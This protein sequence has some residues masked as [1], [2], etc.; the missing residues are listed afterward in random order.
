MKKEYIVLAVVSVLMLQIIVTFEKGE[1]RDHGF[2][3]VYSMTAPFGFFSI[4]GE[5]HGSFLFIDGYI[6]SSENYDV[7]YFDG[8]ILRTIILNAEET[9]VIVD[10]KLLLEREK[11]VDSFDFLHLHLGLTPS[12][13][14]KYTIHIPFLPDVA[15]ITEEWDDS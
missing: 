13:R 4:Q 5:I 11:T 8:N 14:I 9:G 12:L 7:K 10:G 3:D 1:V 2:Y 15:P 6:K